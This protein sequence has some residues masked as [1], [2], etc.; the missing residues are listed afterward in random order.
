MSNEVEIE[1]DPS[2]GLHGDDELL[3]LHEVIYKGFNG[4]EMY[5]TEE[6]TPERE[7]ER[8]NIL[9]DLKLE[10][11]IRMELELYDYPSKNDEETVK[12]KQIAINRKMCELVCSKKRW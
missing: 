1:I 12:R 3:R 7:I 6:G 8:Q 11:L 4:K 9:V 10:N 5:T 2:E